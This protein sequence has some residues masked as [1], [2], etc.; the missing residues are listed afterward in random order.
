MVTGDPHCPTDG[1]NVYVVVP[2]TVVLIDAGLQVPV[3]PSREVA[4]NNGATEF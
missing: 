1:V 3:T 2:A 4:G